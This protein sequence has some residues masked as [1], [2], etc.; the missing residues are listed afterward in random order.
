[1]FLSVVHRQVDAESYA[2]VASWSSSAKK[3]KPRSRPWLKHEFKLRSLLY[4]QIPVFCFVK[5][6]NHIRDLLQPISHCQSDTKWF[7]CQSATFI[8]LVH[9][10]VTKY[11]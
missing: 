5:N 8:D 2:V 10:S 7:D 11:W 4:T 1:M 6:R 9:Q 3:R